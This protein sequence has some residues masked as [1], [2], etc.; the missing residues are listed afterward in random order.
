VW[1]SLGDDPVVLSGHVGPV[2]TVAFNGRGDRVV[3]AGD[4]KTVRIWDALS[5]DGLVVLD[6]HSG[7]ATADFS[8]ATDRVVSASDDGTR[9]LDCEVCGSLSQAVGVARTRAYRTLSAA[10]RHNLLP[11]G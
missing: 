3:S 7:T 8:P 1:I 5:G 6:R 2:E 9:L 10:E 11:G 4:D